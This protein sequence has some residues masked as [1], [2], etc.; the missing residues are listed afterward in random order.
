MAGQLIAHN[1]FIKIKLAKGEEQVDVSP[2]S[3]IAE[4]KEKLEEKYFIQMHNQTLLYNGKELQNDS[5][6]AE[7]NIPKEAT[8]HLICKKTYAFNLVKEEVPVMLADGTYKRAG[9]LK[10][11]D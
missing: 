7:N 3:S 10:K 9:L 5:T 8:L 11:G 4:I 1:M 6:I 2:A